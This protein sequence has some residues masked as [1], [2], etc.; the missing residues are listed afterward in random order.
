MKDVNNWERSRFALT[1]GLVG[2][3]IGSGC[4]V[5]TPEQARDGS[6]QR[7]AQRKEAS[8]ARAAAEAAARE[9]ASAAQPAP[10]QDRGGGGNGH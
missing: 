6:R 10:I 8:A 1:A 3:T 4:M 5:A 2:L 7:V 9:A